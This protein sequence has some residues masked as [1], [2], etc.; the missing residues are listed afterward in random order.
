[1][2]NGNESYSCSFTI[3]TIFSTLP[4][5]WPAPGNLIGSRNLIRKLIG[6]NSCNFSYPLSFLDM[7]LQLL[8]VPLARALR[9]GVWAS[10]KA[11]TAT[12]KRRWTGAVEEPAWLTRSALANAGAS[13]V[14]Y[15]KLSISF[16]F[17]FLS[18]FLDILLFLYNFQFG[19]HVKHASPDASV[20]LK[21]RSLPQFDLRNIF[22]LLSFI[23]QIDDMNLIRLLNFWRSI[24]PVFRESWNSW[25]VKLWVPNLIDLKS[26]KGIRNNHLGFLLNIDF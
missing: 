22:E 1:M 17:N 18:L 25:L 16:R 12:I 8:E 5:S 7:D 19:Q 6:K 10:A 2:W 14:R 24:L 15:S 3:S 23:H 4:L 20:V 11:Y 13:S 9:S 21:R 26:I